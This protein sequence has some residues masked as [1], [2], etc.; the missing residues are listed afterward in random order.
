M[1]RINVPV[2]RARAGQEEGGE[3]R[4]GRIPVG[5]L[6]AGR[7]TSRGTLFFSHPEL[8]A[9]RSQNGAQKG[10]SSTS[11]VFQTPSCC[12]NSPTLFL[13]RCC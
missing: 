10:Q 6:L 2:G 12:K 5:Q 1:K 13:I 7:L 8:E 4:S 9:S 11:Y 3:H